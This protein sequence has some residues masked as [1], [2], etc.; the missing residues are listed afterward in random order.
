[1][2]GA[3]LCR[4]EIKDVTTSEN[5]GIS[6]PRPLD[7]LLIILTELVGLGAQSGLA[8]SGWLFAGKTPRARSR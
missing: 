4:S 7:P 6:T 5:C 1:M 8:D 3:T 2:Q